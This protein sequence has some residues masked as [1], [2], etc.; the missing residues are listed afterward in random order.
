MGK[1]GISAMQVRRSTH[2]S[3]RH[4]SVDHTMLVSPHEQIIYIHTWDSVVY[5]T[6]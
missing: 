6:W 5:G 1:L 4:L 2:P 3:Q